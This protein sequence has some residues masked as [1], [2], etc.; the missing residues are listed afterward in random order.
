MLQRIVVQ[1]DGCWI[2]VGPRNVKSRYGVWKH[3]YV[4]RLVY[5]CLIGPIPKGY[6]IDHT[7]FVR[8][9]CNPAHLE[10]VTSAENKRRAREHYG[11]RGAPVA[12]AAKTHCPRGHPYDEENTSRS[13]AVNPHWRRCRTCHNK[14]ARE[15]RQLRQGG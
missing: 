3:G 14:K 12:M 2:W 7:C 8:A 9:C 10:A 11:N 5:E 15:R 13:S 6:E 1:P 4:H